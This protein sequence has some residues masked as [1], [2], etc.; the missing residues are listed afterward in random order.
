MNIFETPFNY[1]IIIYDVLL[2]FALGKDVCPSIISLI[3]LNYWNNTVYIILKYM[4]MLN[5]LYLTYQY[6]NLHK[7]EV[8]CIER[9]K[10]Y[11][12]EMISKD[13]EIRINISDATIKYILRCMY[14]ILT[15]LI[16]MYTTLRMVAIS[17]I[18]FIMTN[19]DA[20]YWLFPSERLVTVENIMIWATPFIQQTWDKNIIIA[21]LQK[22]IPTISFLQQI[23][24][25]LYV[26][27]GCW[28]TG[29]YD[30][31]QDILFYITLKYNGL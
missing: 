10:E 27:L 21:N 25:G 2:L 1:N 20:K 15:V 19:D 11:V 8:Y 30:N 22:I 17:I 5:N 12:A 6:S 4:F 31:W 14:L 29:I 24:H 13:K 9:Y 7:L 28:I 26:V 16:A 3:I 23:P 18:P